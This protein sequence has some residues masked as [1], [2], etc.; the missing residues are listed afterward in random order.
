MPDQDKNMAWSTVQFGTIVGL[1]IV[2][3]LLSSINTFGTR[4]PSMSE[5]S[6][7]RM[8]NVIQSLQALNEESRTLVQQNRATNLALSQFLEVKRSDRNTTYTELMSKYQ[9]EMEGVIP[10]VPINQSVEDAG[11]GEVHN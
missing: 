6:I 7:H 10:S 8:E 1:L 2:I 9:Q 5:D 11:A 4:K 3:A